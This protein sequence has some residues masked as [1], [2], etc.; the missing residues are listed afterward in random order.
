MVARDAAN[1]LRIAH[2]LEEDGDPEAARRCVEYAIAC[3]RSAAAELRFGDEGAGT[4][5]S[6]PPPALVA[7]VG[8]ATLGSL[9]RDSDELDVARDKHRDAFEDAA[10]AVDEKRNHG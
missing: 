2:E 1:A 8:L 9:A 3:A 7:T 5:E 10:V 6:E 4:V